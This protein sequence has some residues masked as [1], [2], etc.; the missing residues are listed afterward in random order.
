MTRTAEQA[1]SLAEP[2]E[3]LGAEV[4][5]MP[6]LETV[7][8]EDWTPVDDAIR[9]LAEYDWLVLTS[10]NAVGRFLSRFRI[11]GGSREALLGIKIA[12]VGSAT[13][14]WLRHHGLPPTLVPADFRAEGLIAEFRAMGPDACRRVLLPRALEARE[15]FPEALREMGIASP[16]TV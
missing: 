10:T 15:V 9:N 8:P 11:A 14:A 3:E 1:R 2:L 13:A 5:V 12:A 6:V 7:D 4:V 16:A